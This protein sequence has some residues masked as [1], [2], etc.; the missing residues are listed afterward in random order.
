MNPEKLWD[1]PLDSK[2][3]ISRI[4]IKGNKDDHRKNSANILKI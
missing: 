1:P 2:M 3:I 4:G